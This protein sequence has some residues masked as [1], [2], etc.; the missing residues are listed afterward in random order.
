MGQSFGNSLVAEG[1]ITDIQ[2]HVG[3]APLG[4]GSE[5]EN[6]PPNKDSTEKLGELRPTP[7]KRKRD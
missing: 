4:K 1:I 3:D 2:V 6:T 7:R 5:M